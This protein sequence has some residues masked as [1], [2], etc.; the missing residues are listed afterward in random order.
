MVFTIIDV[1]Y[2]RLFPILGIFPILG[3]S[4]S[5]LFIFSVFLFSVDPI[6]NVSYSLYFPILDIFIFQDYF[7]LQEFQFP[8]LA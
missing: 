2:S 1:L 8:I 5:R 3:F 6:L 7:Q 4:Y